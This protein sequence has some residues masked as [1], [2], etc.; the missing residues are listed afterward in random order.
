MGETPGVGAAVYVAGAPAALP[1]RPERYPANSFPEA[2]M[3]DP[4]SLS[5]RVQ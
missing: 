3:Q 1:R 2:E 5:G 4:L